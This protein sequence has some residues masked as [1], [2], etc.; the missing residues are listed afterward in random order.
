[1][2]MLSMRAATVALVLLAAAT[3]ARAE[4]FTCLQPDGRLSFQQL[5]CADGVPVAPHGQSEA[6]R[7]GP[8]AAARAP[9]ALSPIY[10]HHPLTQSQQYMQARS[11]SS[12]AAS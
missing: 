11:A 3:V 4:M 9:E 10:K 2:K 1:M 5:P 12:R 8:A 7:P 6:A